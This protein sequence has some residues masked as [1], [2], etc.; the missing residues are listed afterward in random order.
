MDCSMPG[1]PG[2]NL[3]PK[4]AQTHVH[5]V[6]DATQPSHI[7]SSPSLLALNLSQHWGLFQWAWLSVMECCFM[8]GRMQRRDRGQSTISTSEI[9]AYTLSHFI[10]YVLRWDVLILS[11]PLFYMWENWDLGWMK[12]PKAIHLQVADPASKSSWCDSKSVLLSIPRMVSPTSSTRQDEATSL[13]PA[14]MWLWA[15]RGSP[16]S[17]HFPVLQTNGDVLVELRIMETDTA[18]IPGVLW[19]GLKGHPTHTSPSTAHCRLLKG[20]VEVEAH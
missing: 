16:G 18:D 14:G 20:I 8:P 11:I 10:S 13:L 5:R 1:F 6:G 9:V 2:H 12:L 19:V 15:S 4:F 17:G 3:L 7:L